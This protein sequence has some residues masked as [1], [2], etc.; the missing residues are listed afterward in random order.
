MLKVLRIKNFALMDDLT[1]DFGKGLT[2]I[3]GETGAG[4][5]MIVQAIGSLCGERID[6]ISIRTGKDSA[7]ITGVFEIKPVLMQRLKKAGIESEFDLVVRRKIERGKRQ[8]SYINDQLVSLGLLEEISHEMIDLIG[9]YENQSL[10]NPKNHLNLLDAYAGLVN[11]R[12]EY[13]NNFSEY[14]SQRSRLE[15]LLASVKQRDER[16][17]YLK[18][19]ISEIEKAQ[20]KHGEEAQLN[21]EKDL[22]LS[23]EK[24]SLLSGELISTLYEAEGSVVENLY[25]IQKK[26]E[27][28]KALD[29][30]L[31]EL[32][33]RLT[34]S[35]SV[36]DDIYRTMSSYRDKIEFSQVRFDEVLE[37]L[38]VI[39][40][41]KKKYGKTMLEVSDQLVSLKRELALIEKHDEEIAELTESTQEL[42]KKVAAQ[43]EALSAER[44]RVCGALQKK[45]LT[46][47]GRLGM[48]K[49]K[50][51]VRITNKDPDEN[52]RDEVEFYIST[53]PGEELKPLRRIASGGEISRIT[54]GLKT[55]LKLTKYRP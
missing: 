9:Q 47:L 27:E 41:V 21:L 33:E 51:E 40:R 12:K 10:F 37:R 1:I 36:I 8:I 5:S 19:Q 49:A 15:S 55:I 50:F 30:Q 11:L 14:N 3:T 31:H 23:S 42:E 13:Y 32:N 35:I 54:L 43:A 34:T 26:L 22:L 38:E 48:E 2:V 6:D 52:G 4:K 39:N 46:L 45:I 25:K 7:E 28:L 29:P 18:F 24:R 16:I 17:D 53:N 20:L 44:R